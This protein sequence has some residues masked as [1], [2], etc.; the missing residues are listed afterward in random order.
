M[1]DLPGASKRALAAARAAL[2]AVAENGRT[3]LRDGLGVA[4]IVMLVK[5]AALYAEPAGWIV[6]GAFALAAAVLLTGRAKA[7]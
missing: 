3:L 5:G 2:Q 6:A 4:G 7:D 1:S